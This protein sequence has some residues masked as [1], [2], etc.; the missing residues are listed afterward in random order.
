MDELF[1]IGELAKLQNISR[2][3]LIFYDK[4]GLFK[5]VYID[6]NT[7]Y[8]YYSAKQLDYLDTIMIMKKVGFSLNEIKQQMKNYNTENSN[9]AFEKQIVQIQKQIDELEMTKS[10]VEKRLETS[11]KSFSEEIEVVDCQKM[12]L[13]VKD[14][15]S[16]YLLK[17]VSIATKRLFVEGFKNHLPIYY[18]SGVIVELNNIKEGNYLQAKKAFLTTEKTKDCIT[19]ASGK[20]VVG[21]HRGDYY[22]IGNTYQRILDYCKKNNLTIISDS[23]EFAINDYL[24]TL[25]ESEYITKI[26]FYIKED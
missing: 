13:L 1:S 26:M 4:I 12:Y 5:P 10:R 20:T 7:G 2:Q 21:Y 14:V 22:S 16:P 15:E 8:R 23:Y 17:E 9:L 25:D 6:S 24:S 3:T 18:Q 11:K 19:L